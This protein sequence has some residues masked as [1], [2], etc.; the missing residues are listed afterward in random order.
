MSAVRYD[1]I[2]SQKY[3]T[4]NER[5][6]K[7]ATPATTPVAIVVSSICGRCEKQFSFKED[8]KLKL[9]NYSIT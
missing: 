7:Y 4:R 2:C 8:D 3:M 6:E 1:I 9:I 5:N